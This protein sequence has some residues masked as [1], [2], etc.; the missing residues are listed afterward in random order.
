MTGVL[1]T[2]A[3]IGAGLFAAAVAALALVGRVTSLH[4]R[5]P[6]Q[7]VIRGTAITRGELPRGEE[8]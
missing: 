3:V 6:V 4:V 5:R 7:R 1:A 2:W 8:K